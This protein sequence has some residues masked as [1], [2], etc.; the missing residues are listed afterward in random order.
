MQTVYL[1]A[2]PS[3]TAAVRIGGVSYA[4]DISTFRGVTLVSI[5]ADGV[6]LASG[7]KAVPGS[8]L[9]PYRYK[10]RGGNFRF[11]S[12][13]GD[14][15]VYSDFGGSAALVYYTSAEADAIDAKEA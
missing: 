11:E 3:Q 13:S 10:E 7:V 5:A 9:I 6:P 1:T 8:W 4:I 14:Y 15:P 12:L 2:Q